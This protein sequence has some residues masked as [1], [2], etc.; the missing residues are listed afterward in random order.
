MTRQLIT[1]MVFSTYVEVILIKIMSTAL[2]A[3]FL[4]VCGGDPS[5][6]LVWLIRLK[7]SPRMWR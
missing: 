2:D 4:H 6:R 7:F 5:F 1:L 3:R